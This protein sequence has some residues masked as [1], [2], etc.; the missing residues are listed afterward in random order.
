V[1]RVQEEDCV[2]RTLGEGV[3]TVDDGAGE[4]TVARLGSGGAGEDG[5]GGE[6]EG[7]AHGEEGRKRVTRVRRDREKGREEA[8]E[9]DGEKEKKRERDEKRVQ[10]G[11]GK[12][13][14][15]FEANKPKHWGRK[16]TSSAFC[17]RRCALLQ[18]LG[19]GVG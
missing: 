9:G 11:G 13:G 16:C 18:L 12:E 10:E 6:G 8:K 3:V 14:S 5:E 7:S 19:R 2:Q 1:L 4:A 17:T 15:S